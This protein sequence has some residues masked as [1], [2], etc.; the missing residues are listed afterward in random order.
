[1]KRTFFLD[2]QKDMAIYYGKVS[3][4]TLLKFQKQCCYSWFTIPLC[5]ASFL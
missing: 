4:Y 3:W 2:K 1:M 5:S